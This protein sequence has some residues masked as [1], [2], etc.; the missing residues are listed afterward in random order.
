MGRR[1]RED[2]TTRFAINLIRAESRGELEK[3]KPRSIKKYSI[4]KIHEVTG[5]HAR[6]I[7]GHLCRSATE[8]DEKMW[9]AT[10]VNK[11]LGELGSPLELRGTIP[12]KKEVILYG[13]EYGPLGVVRWPIL[14]R[15]VVWRRTRPTPF[16]DRLEW[17]LN[18]PRIL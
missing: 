3:S 9:N 4:N 11:K 5:T 7:E 10:E 18:R 1:R 8:A 14:P 16:L 12:E 6:T 2:A 15:Q 17:R 13:C